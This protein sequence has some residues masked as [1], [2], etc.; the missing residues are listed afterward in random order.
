MILFSG[1]QWR[2]LEP[3]FKNK[4]TRKDWRSFHFQR[5]PKSKFPSITVSLQLQ[6]QF[7]Y[8]ENTGR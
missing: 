2:I 1:N 3:G 7:S 4:T 6:K 8:L 5:L